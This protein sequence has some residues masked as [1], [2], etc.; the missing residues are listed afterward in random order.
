M[1]IIVNENSISEDIEY[2]C[3][4]K[5]NKNGDLVLFTEYGEGT[6]LGN[7]WNN[8]YVGYYSKT[9]DMSFF[10]FFKGS[11]TFYND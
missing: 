11:V 6:Q 7:H 3:L 5:H 9:W 1:K 10:E 2:P 8:G 4:M